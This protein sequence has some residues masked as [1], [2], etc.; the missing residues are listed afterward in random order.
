MGAVDCDSLSAMQRTG[1]IGP[2]SSWTPTSCVNVGVVALGKDV[3]FAPALSAF[4]SA[5]FDDAELTAPAV[6]TVVTNM[7]AT[8]SA[9][10]EN[11]AK[12]FACRVVL[13]PCGPPRKVDV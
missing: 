6:V 13:V 3:N 11:T 12:A 8:K 1:T 4:C 10:S 9:A 7:L 2:P 5:T